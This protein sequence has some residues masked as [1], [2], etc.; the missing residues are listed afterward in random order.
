MNMSTAIIC[1]LL[2][3]IAIFGVRSYMKKLSQGCCGSGG[4]VEKKIK[5]KDKELSHYPYHRLI[6]IDGMTCKNCVTRIENAFNIEDGCYMKVDL[7]KRMA[8]LYMKSDCDDEM[9]KTRI[10][11]S[12]YKVLTIK[13]I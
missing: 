13:S 6:Q 1:L 5:V 4:D 10:Q 7:K 11:K 8:D 12:G 3:I 9:I 2:V